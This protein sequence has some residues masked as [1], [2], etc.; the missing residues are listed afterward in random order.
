MQTKKLIVSG[1]RADRDNYSYV[2]VLPE[3][4]LAFYTIVSGGLESV[5]CYTKSA[6]MLRAA[7]EAGP[8]NLR[9]VMIKAAKMLAEQEKE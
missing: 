6:D 3:A 2:K 4:G 5:T 1:S 9:N 8:G 7:Q